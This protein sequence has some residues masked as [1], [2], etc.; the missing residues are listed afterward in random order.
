MSKPR[1][2]S[3][4]P[5]TPRDRPPGPAKADPGYWPT[6]V[7]RNTFTRLGRR[8][9]VRGWSVKIQHEGRRRTF[10][11]GSS[12]R[13]EAARRAH[14]LYHAILTTGWDAV[15]ERPGATAGKTPRPVALA[16]ARAS[17]WKPRLI[18]RPHTDGLRPGV[19]RTLAARIE[20]RGTYHYFPLGT[21]HPD[22]AAQAALGIYR[23]VL[24]RGWALAKARFPREITVAVFWSTNPVAC[25][26]TTLFT[27][28]PHAPP[29]GSAPTDRSRT[30]PVCLVE[31]ET[32]VRRALTAWI[33]RQPR[34][35]CDVTLTTAADVLRWAS[36]TRPT[37]VLVSRELPDLPGGTCAAQL[38]ARWP[39]LPVLTYGVYADSDQ[40]FLS[41]TGVSAGYVLRRRPP[42]SLLEPIGRAPAKPPVTARQVTHLVKRYFQGFFES[43][44]QGEASPGLSRL[45]TR[46]QEILE[47]LRKGYVDKEVAQRLG[48]S[49]WT[50]RG[51]LKRIYEKLGV[52]TRTEAVV[53][54]LEK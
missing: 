2:S 45:T 46:E 29:T 5:Q 53:R 25:T 52:H 11:L 7:F 51:H 41:L 13:A 14:A 28:L 15:L 36:A 1:P 44:P 8:F 9:Q 35:R 27:A 39:D 6:R 26:Y 10:S 4:R 47:Q 32:G 38:R 23:A 19:D 18:R 34:F 12:Q 16:R 54:Y 30:V 37:V 24:T 49:A 48:I 17:Y 20:H 22:E 33:D 50:V 3:A 42:D 21:D 43:S 40:L 31:P